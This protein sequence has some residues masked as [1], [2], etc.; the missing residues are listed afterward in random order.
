MDAVLTAIVQ[1]APQLGLSGVLVTVIVI[2]VKRETTAESRHTAEV[3]RITRVH[4]A[5]LAELRTELAE[6]RKQVRD[7]NAALDVESARRR[8]AEDNTSRRPRRG[9]T[10]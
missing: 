1:T 4:D 5:E 3:D 9:M 10:S 2:L 7:L 8:E 6:V